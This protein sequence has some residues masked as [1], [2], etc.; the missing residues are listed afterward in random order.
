MRR[1]T[2]AAL[3]V[4]SSLVMSASARAHGFGGHGACVAADVPTAYH[5]AFP[6]RAA[7]RVAV[8]TNF[9]LLVSQDG[10]ETFGWGCIETY[11]ASPGPYFLEDAPKTLDVLGDGTLYVLYTIGYRESRDGGCGYRFAPDPDLVNASVVAV[12]DAPASPGVTYAVASAPGTPPFGVFTSDDGGVDFSP[13]GLLLYGLG[14]GLGRP[15]F[16]SDGATLYTLSLEPDVGVRVWRSDDGAVTWQDAVPDLAV[17]DATL[18]G[19]DDA[20]PAVLY[21]EVTDQPRSPCDFRT[22]VL[23]SDDSGASFSPLIERS[24]DVLTGALV[25]DDGSLWLAWRDAGLERVDGSGAVTSLLERPLSCLLPSDGGV[26]L[27][28]R[29][30]APELVV[31]RD[32]ATSALS[33]VVTLGQVVGPLSCPAGTPA[34][35]PCE[36][37][38]LD[39]AALLGLGPTALV[40]GGSAA[41]DA[42]RSDAAESDAGVGGA[43]DAGG[44]DAGGAVSGVL[45][46]RCAGA[47][48][49]L[50]TSVWSLLLPLVLGSL[51]AAR[52]RRGSP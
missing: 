26:L 51:L 5:A 14:T 3:A 38:W 49:P 17:S 11:G 22:R 34:S 4:L 39:A 6:A 35:G 20:D 15:V 42:G 24:G 30:G 40:D 37:R 50:S 31:A 44:A 29:D 46:C 43:L 41:A 32:D 52:G 16:T 9:G 47:I 13:T 36:A 28:P 33:P 10:G 25:R 19:V 23:R 1:T 2:V 48:P 45:S 12:T 27:C 18:L 7:G 8:M 21:L